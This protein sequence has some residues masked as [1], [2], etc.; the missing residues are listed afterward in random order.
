MKEGELNQQ[1]G[2]LFATFF[3][4]ELLDFDVWRLSAK[5]NC[6]TIGGK[7]LKIP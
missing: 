3:F 1:P 7:I 6:A 4:G 2:F 5:F